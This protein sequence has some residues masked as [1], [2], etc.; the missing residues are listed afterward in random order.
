[1]GGQLNDLQDRAKALVV[2]LLSRLSLFTDFEISE[3]THRVDIDRRHC[4]FDQV[5]N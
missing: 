4:A 5:R 3:R 1:V 2:A